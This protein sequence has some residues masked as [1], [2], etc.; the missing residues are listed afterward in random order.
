[1]KVYL[2]GP[3]AGFTYEEANKWR[4]E[5]TDKLQEFGVQTLNPLRGRMFAHSNDEI[6]DPKELVHRDL[7]DIRACD[8]V[9]AY[10]NEPSLGTAMEIWHTHIIEN[11]PVILVSDNPAI[12]RHPWIVLICTKIYATFDEA[13]NY[14]TT[15]WADRDA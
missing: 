3:I 6:V 9:L 7:Q 15:R 2:S 10:M 1:M 8:L 4:T 5:V 12:R 11:K 14:I 13:V